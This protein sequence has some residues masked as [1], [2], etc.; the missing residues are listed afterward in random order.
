MK[1]LHSSAFV[2]RLKAYRLWV[3]G[4][5]MV[6]AL[7]AGY[8]ILGTGGGS[9][10]AAGMLANPLS[11][12]AERS[13]GIRNPG[14][15]AQTKRAYAKTK[16]PTRE[17]TSRA[18]NERVLSNLRVR[19]PVAPIPS[20]SDSQIPQSV[21]SSA[22]GSPVLPEQP[23]GF[24]VS[25]AAP[26]VTG[27]TGVVGFPTGGGAGGPPGDSGTPATLVSAVPEPSDWLMSIAGFFLIGTFLRSH[28]LR[29]A[30]THA[31]AWARS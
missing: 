4:S 13:P 28:R 8:F 23:Q 5:F 12:F 17:G 11:V 31:R 9:A 6:L 19:P 26:G 2:V 27:G 10:L 22:L 16:S 14:A 3:S 1:I 29:A 18:P 25:L 15:L 30:R 7:A 24:P 21:G 20:E